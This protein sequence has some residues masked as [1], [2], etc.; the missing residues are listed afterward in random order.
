MNPVE[1][2]KPG[3]IVGAE[4]GREALPVNQ[5][6]DQRGDRP[7]GH[8][9]GAR[10]FDSSPTLRATTPNSRASPSAGGMDLSR[11]NS[12]RAE[13]PFIRVGGTARLYSYWPP[14]A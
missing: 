13:R 6:A 2:G 5:Q 12:T 9:P 1:T 4:P 11:W 14:R 10:H 3:E 8:G 7:P